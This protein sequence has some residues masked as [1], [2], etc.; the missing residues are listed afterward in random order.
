[1]ETKISHE[2]ERQI[3]YKLFFDMKKDVNELKRMFVDHL[4]VCHTPLPT[5]KIV[6]LPVNI[7]PILVNDEET[8]NLAAIEKAYIM[9]AL[10][11]NRDKRKYAALDLGISERTLYRKLREHDIEN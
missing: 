3:L 11:K 8:L 10:K 1:M 9:K 6:D 7:Q 4:E 2:E 5:T